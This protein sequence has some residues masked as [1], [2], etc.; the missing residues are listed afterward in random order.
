M[1]LTSLGL[2]LD[3]NFINKIIPTIPYSLSFVRLFNYPA[4]TL[5]KTRADATSSWG[6][7]EYSDYGLFTMLISDSPGL[8]FYNAKEGNWLYA[9]FLMVLFVVVVMCWIE[10]PMDGLLVQCIEQRIQAQN[11]VL[12]FHFSLILLGIHR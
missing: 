2:G 1:E 9:P 11:R 7:G 8:Q 10:C 6:I 5:E 3:T 12:A 4:T